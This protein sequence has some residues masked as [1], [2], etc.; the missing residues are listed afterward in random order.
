MELTFEGEIQLKRLHKYCPE[1]FA[2][3]CVR[4]VQVRNRGRRL[5]RFA[6]EKGAGQFVMRTTF[7]L[8]YLFRY[9]VRNVS[10]KR[11]RAVMLARAGN[12]GERLR[13]AA[14]K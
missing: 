14:N 2:A 6:F 13:A 5:R 3:G 7:V 12:A 9:L 4:E 8:R 10:R 1:T 11:I